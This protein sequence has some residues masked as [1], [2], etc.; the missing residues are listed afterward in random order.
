M[1]RDHGPLPGHWQGSPTVNKGPSDHALALLSAPATVS[2]DDSQ[3]VEP[4]SIPVAHSTTSLH[5]RR[6][7][8]ES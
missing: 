8:A 5:V 1:A 3:A 6:G 4:G 2:K 7:A